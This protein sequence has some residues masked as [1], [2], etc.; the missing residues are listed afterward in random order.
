MCVT[1]DQFVDSNLMDMH[2]TNSTV[3][4]IGMGFEDLACFMRLKVGI[5]GKP[6]CTR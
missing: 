3:K 6:L 1:L 2:G 5:F 4:F